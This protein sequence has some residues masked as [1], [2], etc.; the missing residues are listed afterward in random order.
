MCTSDIFLTFAKIAQTFYEAFKNQKLLCMIRTLSYGHL[1]VIKKFGC[2]WSIRE[3]LALQSVPRIM[4][5][6]V[7]YTALDSLGLNSPKTRSQTPQ[8]REAVLKQF[9]AKRFTF[10]SS[11]KLS[12][13]YSTKYFRYLLLTPYP[14]PVTQTLK[15][16]ARKAWK[17]HYPTLPK[18]G[19]HQ[20]HA[21]RTCPMR[22]FKRHISKES[23]KVPDWKP[24]GLCS[25]WFQRLCELQQ[26]SSPPWPLLAWESWRGHSAPYRNT[27]RTTL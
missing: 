5:H 3:I 22:I 18:T 4:R 15:L 9:F 17:V 25:L 19:H 1:K 20:K 2:N 23:K 14:V 27:H 16:E 26:S 12:K 7:D 6:P 10:L 8:R 13:W 11:G 21:T 24:A